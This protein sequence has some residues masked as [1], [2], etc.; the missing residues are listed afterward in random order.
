MID[1]RAEPAH[2]GDIIGVVALHR[3]TDVGVVCA[4]HYGSLVRVATFLPGVEIWL[5]GDT[6]KTEPEHHQL[7]PIEDRTG[8]ERLFDQYLRDAQDAG[9][10]IP[11][12]IGAERVNS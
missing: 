10:V 1:W 11:L 12:T 2:P 4:Q 5:P 9:W 8:A 6:P 3:G 7:F